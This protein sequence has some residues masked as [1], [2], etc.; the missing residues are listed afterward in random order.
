MSLSRRLP[1]A[2]LA[3]CVSASVAG[4]APAPLEAYGELP[5][6]ESIEISPDGSKLALAMS[7]SG[8]RMLAVKPLPEGPLQTFSLGDAKIRGLDWM[9]AGSLI[10]TASQTGHIPG[11]TGGK[12][13]NFMGYELNL[14]TRKVQPLL[15]GADIRDTA[16]HG[17][18]ALNVLAGAPEV[19]TVDGK[20][21]LFLRG[22]TFPAGYSVLT[23]FDVNLKAGRADVF[24]LGGRY[25]E[26]MVLGADGRAI[27]QTEY[28]DK[29][30]RWTLK[31]R[32][33]N[34]WQVNRTLEAKL[35]SPSLMGLGRTPGSVVVAETGEDGFKLREV[36]ADGVWGEPLQIRDAD[37][38]LFDPETH[39]LIGRHALEGDEERYTF[40]DPADQAAW[41]LVRATF[42]GDRVRLASWSADRKKI[43]VLADS[44]TEGEAYALV[45]LNAKQ[46]TW[47]GARYERL[48]AEDISP[49]QP[50]TFK[51]ADGLELHGY[52]TIPSGADAKNLPLVVFPHGG[53][54]A[55]DIPG[56]DWWAQAMAS[57][58]YAVLQVNYR[59]SDGYG[60]SFLQAGFGQWG[61]KMQTDLSDGVRHLVAKGIVDPK[62]VCI[63]GASYGGYAALAGAALDTG[64]YRC[65]VSVAGLSD[66]G[67][68]VSW[69]KAER[70]QHAFRYWTRFM[71]A[72][73]DR[74]ETLRAISPAAHVDR[75]TIPVL[76][77]HG[78][79]DTVVPL[80]QSRIMADALRKAGKPF[81]LVVQP[82]AD[83][84]LSRGDTRL[85]TLQ[86]TLGFLEKHNPPR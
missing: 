11:L 53:P 86:A 20:P 80:E 40:F 65:A 41:D 67:R 36:S 4:A 68:M 5:S 60:W 31:L 24:E 54:A 30:G 72:E 84:W 46:A 55:R 1:A 82:G 19:R 27:A 2:V 59:G 50:V 51:A 3:A 43:V 28:D 69:S 58:G 71:G 85:Q 81:E 44:P 47:L 70:G 61:R 38:A 34:G 74:A 29:S 10:I 37:G 66:L 23:V 63:V 33:T 13:E 73:A 49:V 75:V 25:T 42:K 39:R 78:R 21:R 22:L 77:V 64:V 62:R 6:I 26:D 12:R 9:G 79:D 76:L 14:A 45:D 56:F 52:L 83:H 32:R 57:R 35:D 48:R 18:Y 8:Q 16:T 7:A 15:R 17:S